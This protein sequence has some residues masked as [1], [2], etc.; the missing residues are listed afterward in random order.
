MHGSPIDVRDAVD[1]PSEVRDRRAREDLRRAGDAAEPSGEVERPASVAAIDGHG[2]PG[3]Q[4]D[5]DREGERGV[6]DR[7]VDEP[8]LELDR[9]PDRLPDRV[10]DHERFV[11]AEL[12]HHAASSLDALP[13]HPGELHRQRR[14]GLV[15]T[16]LGE[17]GVPADIGDQERP[18]VGVIRGVEVP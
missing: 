13:R 5:A 14:G 18:D 8:A 9:S 17:D 11:P 3:V 2:L 15:A 7:F 12:D 4:P 1:L 16:L 6:R 10:E